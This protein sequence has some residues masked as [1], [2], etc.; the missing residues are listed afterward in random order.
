M[1]VLSLCL[2]ALVVNV[3]KRGDKKLPVPRWVEKVPFKYILKAL[4]VVICRSICNL[5]GYLFSGIY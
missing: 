5:N 3:M 2:S 4:R 1:I